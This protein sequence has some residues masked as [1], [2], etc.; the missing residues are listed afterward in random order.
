MFA[1]K[2]S[3]KK[4][5]LQY[6]FA[7]SSLM[8]EFLKSEIERNKSIVELNKLKAEKLKLEI[9]RLKG[10]QSNLDTCQYT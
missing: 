5:V 6:P 10:N 2:K 1:G 9:E 7:E 8:E 3:E 4:S